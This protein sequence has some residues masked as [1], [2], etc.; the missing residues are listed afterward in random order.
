MNDSD[1]RLAVAADML[2][3]LGD[4]ITPRQLADVLGDKT[5]EP[6]LGY[7]RAGQFVAID[8]GRGRYSIP[9]KNLIPWLA[10]RLTPI[11]EENR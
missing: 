8:K 5:T 6:V 4:R 2:A 11:P 7:I 3:D 10:A 1:P 9:K